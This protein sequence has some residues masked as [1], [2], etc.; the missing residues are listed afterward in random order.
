MPSGNKKTE[1]QQQQSTSSNQIDPAQLAL[2]TQ[3]YNGAQQKASTLTPYTGQ[4]TAGFNPT[5]TQAQGILS[6]IGTDPSYGATNNAAVGSINGILGSNPNTT[7][8]ASPVDASTIAG[9][10]L[11]KYMNPFQSSVIDASI[12]QNERARQIAGVS[13]NQKAQAAGAFG[14]SRSG[15]LS[16]LTNEAYDRNNQTNIAN[17]NAANF[18]QAQGA[19]GTDAAT[20]N[21][22]GEFNSGQSVN[23]QQSSIQNALAQA[24]FKVNAAGQLINAN[25]AALGTATNQAGILASVGDAQ[26]N[27]QQTELTNAYNAYQ[28]G[29]QLTVAQQ[30]LLNSALGLIPTQQTVTGSGSSTGTSKTSG[31]TLSGILGTLAGG[32]KI[33]AALYGGGG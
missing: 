20:R 4:L 11:S 28:Q 17:L 26:Q 27:Q 12:A 23:A 29:Q 25:N 31:D 21:Q 15:V 18:S 3:N 8:N 2:L 13:D 32:A 1:T 19:A 10:D 30:Q 14:G 24:G 22:V 16:S 7:V 5:Q 6:G 9:S 33:G